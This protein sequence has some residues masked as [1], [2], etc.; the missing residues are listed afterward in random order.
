MLFRSR[1]KP[2]SDLEL[3]KLFQL[4]EHGTRLE[5]SGVEFPVADQEEIPAT[6]ARDP[7]TFRLAE[8]HL[9]DTVLATGCT[10][11][12]LIDAESTTVKPF[13]GW[14]LL[15][16]EKSAQIQRPSISGISSKTEP[17]F[18][19]A[20]SGRVGDRPMR[21]ESY[22][23]GRKRKSLAEVMQHFNGQV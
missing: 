18:L 5:L 4:R 23:P 10:G 1:Q 3:S 9:I 21:A 16:A 22:K 14:W 13:S 12:M 8:G 17:L 11:T 6:Y 2:Y 7:I 19:K 20:K 15:T